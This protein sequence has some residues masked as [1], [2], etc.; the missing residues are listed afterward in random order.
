MKAGRVWSCLGLVGLLIA[1]GLA[2][3]QQNS[4][5]QNLA[6]K[7]LDLAISAAKQLMVQLEK[8]GRPFAEGVV[9]NAPTYYKATQKTLTDFAK[10]VEKGDLGKTTL[11][12]KELLLELWRMRGAINVMSFLDPKVLKSYTGIDVPQLANMKTLLGNTEKQLKKLNFPG[13]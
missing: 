5:S 1:T 9:K 3:P 10:R 6:E 4:A 13:I 7:S 12:Q 2:N 11:Q 8:Q